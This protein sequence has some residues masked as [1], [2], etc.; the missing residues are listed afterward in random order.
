[1][2]S[3]IIDDS[4]ARLLAPNF[5]PALHVPKSC[6]CVGDRLSLNSP[7]VSGDDHRQG[8]QHVEIANQRDP[9]L[10]PRMT[11]AEDTKACQLAA[12]IDIARLPLRVFSSAEG[13]ELSEKFL[14]HRRDNFAH[15]RTVPTGDQPSVAGHQI[16][17]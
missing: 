6:Q 17:E 1:M 15:M 16:H 14:A 11:F 2:M 13:F 12:V 9:E 5:G 4:Y 10:A 7:G 3:K 8:I